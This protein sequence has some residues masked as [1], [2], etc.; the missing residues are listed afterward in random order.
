MTKKVKGGKIQQLKPP[1]KSPRGRKFF[2]GKDETV[3]LSKLEQAF[4]FGASDP[5]ACLYA[6]ISVAALHRYMETHEEFR[7][8]KK[9]LKQQPV[10]M[11]RQAVVNGLKGD[12]EFSF[13]YLA[14]KRP[15]EFGSKK[16]VRNLNT[17]V[18]LS[19]E[20]EKILKGLM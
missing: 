20:A 7:E 14:R 3:V 9:L 4:L 19:E 17:D 16:F 10:L 15:G 13:R 12:K 11:A 8:R 1:K 2:D 5:E 6:D 18:P